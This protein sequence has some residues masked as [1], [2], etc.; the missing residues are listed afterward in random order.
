MVRGNTQLHK[1]W[2][3]ASNRRHHM[4]LAWAEFFRDW[5]VL[6]CPNAATAAFPHSMP[7]ERWE[8]MIDREGFFEAH[9]LALVDLESGLHE[10]HES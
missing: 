10:R 9:R 6:L 5:D 8:R 3:I 4:R 1:D 2:L 7:G